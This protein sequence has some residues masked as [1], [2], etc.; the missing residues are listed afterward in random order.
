MRTFICLALLTSTASAQDSLYVSAA[1]RIVGTYK[2]KKSDHSPKSMAVA[3]DAFLKSLSDGQRKKCLGQINSEV[4]RQ[5]TN[6]P[7]RADADGIRMGELNEA[8]VKAACDLMGALFSKQGY[9]KMRNIMLADDQ[10]LPNGKP[11]QGFGTEYFSVVIFGEPSAKAPWGFQLDGHHIGVNVSVE[12]EKV[13]MSPSFIGT[14]PDA[15]KIATTQYRPLSTE[16]DTAEKLVGA[17][18]D[19]QRKAAVLGPKR[20]RIDYGPGTDGKA[21]RPRGVKCS[22]FNDEQKKL[23]V[24]LISQWVNDLPEKQ[25]RLRMKQLEDEVDLMTFAWSGPTRPK[26]DISYYITGP[27]LIIEYACQSLGGNPLAHLHTMYRNPKNEYGG[28]MKKR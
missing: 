11:R 19:E 17:L 23:L 2:P 15:F 10:L 22:T 26:S 25:A 24:T 20:G 13:A 12:G 1:S 14:Q 16:T 18:N 8:Q 4:R 7:A 6:L 21:G 3:A 27:S 9:Q 28:Q 5:W